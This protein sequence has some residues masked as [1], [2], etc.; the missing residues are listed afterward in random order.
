M[1]SSSHIVFESLFFA[2]VTIIIKEL[3]DFTQTKMRQAKTKYNVVQLTHDWT[4]EAIAI[5]NKTLQ[6]Y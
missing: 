1:G 3:I 4:T 2:Q 6:I 5:E